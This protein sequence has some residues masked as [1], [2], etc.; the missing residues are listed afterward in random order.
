NLA[1]VDIKWRVDDLRGYIKDE[2]VIEILAYDVLEHLPV[3][4]VAGAL[5]EWLRILEPKGV[6]DIRVPDLDILA[7]TMYKFKNNYA[8]MSHMVDRLY[9]GQDYPQNFHCAG[10]NLTIMKKLLEE[11]RGMKITHMSRGNCNLR[12]IAQKGEKTCRY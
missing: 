2:T 7:E 5:D 12:V 10:F 8:E 4:K 9:G 3:K 6:L 1:R 11:E